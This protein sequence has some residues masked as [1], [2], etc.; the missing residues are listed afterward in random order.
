MNNHV[1]ITGGSGLVGSRLTELLLAKGYTVSHLSRSPAKPSSSIP[2]YQWDIK[3]QSIDPQA[4]AD[5]DYVIHLAGAGVADQRWTDERKQAILNSRTE[6]TKLLRDAIAQA[7]P[8]TIK[9]FVSASAI[10]IY[11]ADTGDV[12]LTEESPAADDFLADV[13]VQ[14]EAA[15]DTVKELGVRTVK[16]R[17]G[18]VLSPDGGALPPIAQTVRWG[19]GAPLGSGEQYLSWIH[20]D[21]LCRL[22]IHALENEAVAGAYNAVGP[23]PVTNQQLTQAVARVMH[24]PLWM[25]KVP[26]FVLKLALGELASAVLGGNRVSD[27]KIKDAGF[28]P[29]F[30]QLDL[31]LADLLK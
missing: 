11:G 20:I 23:Q 7:G 18:I 24:R 17:I 14:W 4:L 12:L 3:Q 2:T 31:A 26:G 27:Q 16:C 30:N 22:F 10:G 21:D 25:P 1:L 6:S 13:V 15:V 5:A 29:K 8:S 9:A 28:R 19:V